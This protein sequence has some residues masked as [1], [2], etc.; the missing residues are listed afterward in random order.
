MHLRAINTFYIPLYIVTSIKKYDHPAMKNR[1]YSWWAGGVTEVRKPTA[2]PEPSLFLVPEPT[3]AFFQ[4]TPGSA[5]SWLYVVLILLPKSQCS[6]PLGKKNIP[7]VKFAKGTIIPDASFLN[8]PHLQQK[9][10]RPTVVRG[11]TTNHFRNH[12]VSHCLNQPLRSSRCACS[13]YVTSEC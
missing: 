2:V 3:V 4:W 10:E 9:Q 7:R 11:V 6:Y 12:Q 1:K 8:P 13:D 5:R